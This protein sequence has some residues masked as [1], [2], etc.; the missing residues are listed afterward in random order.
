[1]KTS[2]ELTSAQNEDKEGEKSDFTVSTEKY[3][4]NL[5]QKGRN[6]Q[7]LMMWFHLSFSTHSEWVSMYHD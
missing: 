1:M 4:G 7:Q 3:S 5:K 6:N 2:I